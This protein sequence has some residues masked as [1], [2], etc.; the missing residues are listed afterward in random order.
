MIRV[1][2]VWLSDWE[3]PKF[4]FTHSQLASNYNFSG[5]SRGTLTVF[6]HMCSCSVVF[7]RILR[8]LC[9]FIHQMIDLK[10][11]SCSEDVGYLLGCVGIGGV[12]SE[13]TVCASLNSS[14]IINITSRLKSVEGEKAIYS[15]TAEGGFTTT[16]N[17]LSVCVTTCVCMNECTWAYS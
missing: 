6:C 5:V 15:S 10:D 12:L 3:K 11:M 4:N 1:D 8:S 16:I 9:A 2:R 13:Q 17:Y 7:Q 14:G